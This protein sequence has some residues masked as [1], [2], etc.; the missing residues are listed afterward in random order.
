MSVSERDA[1]TLYFSMIHSSM[2]YSAPAGTLERKDAEK[3]NSKITQS[4]LPTMGYNRNTPLV[5]VYGPKNIGGIGIGLKD[6]FAKQGAAKADK[7]H[8][9]IK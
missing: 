6:L 1:T 3:I 8:T 2:R 4:I 9:I 7:A 5:I